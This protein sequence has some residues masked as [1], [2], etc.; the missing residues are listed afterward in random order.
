MSPG[1]GSWAACLSYAPVWYAYGIEVRSRRRKVAG[2][3][4]TSIAHS[5]ALYVIDSAGDERSGYLMPF[6]AHLVAED[7]RALS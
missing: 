1:T 7:V 4:F 2:V 6:S 5:A 3:R